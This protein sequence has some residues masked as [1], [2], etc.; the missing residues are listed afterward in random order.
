MRMTDIRGYVLA[1]GHSSRM[2]S[3]KALLA[4]NHHT[5]IEHQCE[6]LEPFCPQGVFIAGARSKKLHDMRWPVIQDED[7]DQGP[8]SGFSGTLSRRHSCLNGCQYPQLRRTA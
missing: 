7:Q 3:D 5:A 8:L 2:G 4:V 6:L 1:G